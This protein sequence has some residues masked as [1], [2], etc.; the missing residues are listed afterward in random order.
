MFNNGLFEG[1][2]F[3]ALG[4]FT[5]FTFK[6]SGIAD[7]INQEKF[8][9]FIHIRSENQKLSSREIKIMQ[10]IRVVAAFILVIIG[11]IKIIK[12]LL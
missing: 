12:S 10:I 8:E 9:K 1:I 5:Y 2:V 6:Q 4:I 11:L 3:I 7:A